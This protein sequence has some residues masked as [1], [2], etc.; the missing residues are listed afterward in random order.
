[1]K[2]RESYRNAQYLMATHHTAPYYGK[3]TLINCTELDEE[4]I[5]HDPDRKIERMMFESGNNGWGDRLHSLNVVNIAAAH[6][7]VFDPDHVHTTSNLIRDAVA[8]YS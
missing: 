2:I 7:D 1:S 3:V 6:D 8:E 4:S 5:R